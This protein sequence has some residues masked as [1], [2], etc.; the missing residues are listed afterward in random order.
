[1]TTANTLSKASD[2]ELAAWVQVFKALGDPTR[3]AI[4][5][6]LAAE[7]CCVCDLQQALD[8]PANLLSHHLRVLRE[9]GLV[10]DQRRG[11]WVDY[12]LNEVA[13][14]QLREVLQ[15][16]PNAKHCAAKHASD[17]SAASKASSRKSLE[18]SA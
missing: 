11:R 6:Y 18:V 16:E 8:V 9:A 13:L 17:P 3:L 4:V 2:S 1:M 10:H 7:G 14:S 15:L 5:R 12:R